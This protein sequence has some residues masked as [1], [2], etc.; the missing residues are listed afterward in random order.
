MCD[1]AGDLNRLPVTL[2]TVPVLDEMVEAFTLR[3][4][5]FWALS[6]IRETMGEIT[7]TALLFQILSDQAYGLKQMEE[8]DNGCCSKTVL[9]DTETRPSVRTKP[10]QMTAVLL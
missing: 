2:A 6:N 4:D 7:S 10:S 1:H 5:N 9:V 3:S 8:F